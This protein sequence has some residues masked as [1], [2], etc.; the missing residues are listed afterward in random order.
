MA[1]HELDRAFAALAD[2]TRRD[3]A[4]RLTLADATVAELAPTYD[5]CP[6]AI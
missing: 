3:I 4:P 1:G 5:V 2:G 6:Q